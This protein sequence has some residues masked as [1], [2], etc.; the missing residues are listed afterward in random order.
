MPPKKNN[1][2]QIFE[3]E[4]FS[5]AQLPELQGKKEEIKTI[6]DANPIVE[7]IDNETYEQAKKSRT[8][9][10]TLRT[11]IEREQ[12]DVKKK[13]K[14]TILDAVDTE[15]DTLVS[16]IKIFSAPVAIPLC[17]AI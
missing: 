14:D 7:I 12:K 13:I 10:R 4:K 6:I 15:Y 17:K 16:G 1:E 3:I 9:V 8:A 5:I 11:G 2:I